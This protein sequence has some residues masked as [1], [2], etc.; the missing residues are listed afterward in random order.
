MAKSSLPPSSPAC[1]A[2]DFLPTASWPVLRLRDALLRKL[3]SFFHDR[4]FIEV[5]TPLLS[6]DVV[7]DRHL[8]PFGV[9]VPCGAGRRRMWL[10]TS[11]EFAMKRL[12]ATGGGA[13]FQVTHAFRQEEQGPLHNPEFTMVEWYRRG[14]GLSEGM[15]LL[16]DLAD[17]LLARGPADQISYQAAFERYAGIEPHS[18]TIAALADVARRRGVPV[19][20]SLG[21]DRDAWLDLLLVELLQ[22]HLGRERPAIV[23]D[24][25]ASQAALA[26]VRTGP[27]EIAER[28]ELYIDG[29]EL[30]NGY[31]ELLDAEVLRRRNCENNRRRVAAG[32]LALPEES[33]LLSA[34]ESGLPACCGVALGFD[35]VVMLAAQAAQISDVIAFPFDRA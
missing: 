33:R 8:E 15:Q 28:F 6:A 24:Y 4:G 30:A 19:P 3:R 11:P 7:V 27:P 12:L 5:D 31:H 9:D 21:D 14:D 2:N 13:I 10:Q 26:C 22:P 35:R 23:Y 29:L 1:A 16:G 20:Q 25:P 17:A 34:M 18:A 32:K